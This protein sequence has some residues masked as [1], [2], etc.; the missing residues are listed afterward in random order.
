[1]AHQTFNLAV[2]F[3]DIAG[4]SSLYKQEGDLAAKTAV[5]AVFSQLRQVTEEHRGR[6]IKTIGDEIMACFPDVDDACMAAIAMQRKLQAES[7]L[8][9]KIGVHCGLCLVDGEDIFG[10]VVNDAAAL[11]RIARAEQIVLSEALVNDALEPVQ[12]RARAFDRVKFKGS[13]VAQT[14]YLLEWA[15]GEAPVDMTQVGGITATR[16]GSFQ[17]TLTLYF[18]DKTAE[19]SPRSGLFRLGRDSSSNQWAVNTPVA[20]RSH[21]TIEYR[22]GKFVL[23]DH[24]TNG[25]YVTMAGQEEVHLRREELPLVGG[26]RISLG[27]S[28]IKEPDL[29]ITFEVT[30]PEPA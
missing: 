24:S 11:V 17:P 4:S 1:M 28:A 2:L 8:S 21:L 26:G 7:R 14:V 10:E 3:A 18:H 9:V 29:A 6:V 12:N 19:L 5:D 16:S 27:A 23:V 20:S 30:V 25:T 13:S 22:R 15:P